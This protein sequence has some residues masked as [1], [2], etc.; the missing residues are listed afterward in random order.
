MRQLKRIEDLRSGDIVRGKAT[1]NVFHVIAIYGDRATAVQVQDLTNPD[2]WEVLE[3]S[4]S[5]SAHSF[6]EGSDL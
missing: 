6:T 3:Q 4:Q 2:E 1:G 5:N